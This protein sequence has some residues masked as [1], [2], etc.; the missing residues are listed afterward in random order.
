MTA[1]L[2][3][4]A[5]A[6]A[7]SQQRV[8]SLLP[9]QNVTVLR[10]LTRL[11]AWIR[12]RDAPEVG[13]TVDR[14]IPGPDGSI[15]VRIYRPHGSGPF[16]TIV[17]CHGGGFVSGSLASQDALCRHLTLSSDCVVVS[18]DYRLAPEHPFPAAVEDAI[19][20][21]E[22][23]S[24]HTDDLAGT[25]SLGVAGDSAGGT[26]AAAVALDGRDSA[27]YSVD[28]QA[29]L[30]PSIG[31]ERDQESVRDH[32]GLVLSEA[33]LEWFRDCYYGSDIHLQNPYADPAQVCDCAGLPPATILT[34]GYDP[35]RDGAR[36][37]AQRL[38]DSGVEARHVEYPGMIHGFASMTDAID[39]AT[40]AIEDIGSDLHAALC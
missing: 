28:Y 23:A 37:Y 18:V 13:R 4:Q 6:V 27:D 7:Q 29:L 3:P 30:Y 20:A 24:D 34:A 21:T 1:D 8:R 14:T 33:D 39:R 19:A 32:T 2:H 15:P 26:L 31:V 11:G 9:G 36:E 25:G 10:A 40:D 38:A 16:P 35:L 17:Y 12:N 5:E 22:W